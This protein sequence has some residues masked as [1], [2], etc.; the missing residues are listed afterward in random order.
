MSRIIRAPYQPNDPATAARANGEFA[1]FTQPGAIDEFNIRD[2]AIDLPQLD[3]QSFLINAA[4]AE[5]GTGAAG[6]RHPLPNQAPSSGV[7]PVTKTPLVDAL[8]NPTP[9]GPIAWTVT[10]GEL[11]RVYWDLSVSAT[12]ALTPWVG[13]DGSFDVPYTLGPVQVND[14]GHCWL[15][16]LQWDLTNATLTNWVDVT[17]QTAYN[18]AVGGRVGGKLT[19]SPAAVPVPAWRYTTTG[20]NNGEWHVDA[21]K[22]VFP[23]GWTSANGAWYFTPAG[24]VTIYGFRLVIHGIYH[25]ASTATENYLVVD[26]TVAAPTQVL[27]YDGGALTA[28]HQRIGV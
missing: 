14:G 21:L 5:I 28:I 8:G 1:A 12:Y 18:T 26:T 20:M 24:P 9:L 27:L 6:W 3:T 17:G 23:T 22:E 25:A 4:T 2:A 16:S 15:I 13:A 11:L 7:T 19:D 10:S